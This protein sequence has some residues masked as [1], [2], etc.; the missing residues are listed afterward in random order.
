LSS[1]DYVDCTA[2]SQISPMNAEADKD[3]PA[4]EYTSQADFKNTGQVKVEV[5]T[6]SATFGYSYTSIDV[7]DTKTIGAGAAGHVILRYD[8]ESGT[9][10]VSQIVVLQPQVIG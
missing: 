3:I 8:A 4:W 9:Q 1:G 10:G 6:P 7:G 5:G 2:T